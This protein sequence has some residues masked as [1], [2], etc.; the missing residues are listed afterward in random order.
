M[1]DPSRDD[2]TL[3]H[4]G[5]GRLDERWAGVRVAGT[6]GFAPLDH[7]WGAAVHLP[8]VPRPRLRGRLHQVAFVVSI[9]AGLALVAPARATAAPVGAGVLAAT[10][11]AAWALG[12]TRY[13]VT[14]P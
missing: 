8:S 7:A 3:I 9:P 11:G 13:M 14:P 10:L 5:E 12:H 4:R 2:L 1:D 6:A